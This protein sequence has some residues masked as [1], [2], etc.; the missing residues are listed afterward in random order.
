[1]LTR[2]T[3]EGEIGK[4][5]GISDWVKIDQARISAFADATEDWQAIHLDADAGREAGFDGAVAHGYLTLSMLSHL[6]Y[7]ALPEIEG[8]RASV[9]YGFDR[10]R[11]V[12]PVLAGAR[13]RAHFKLTGVQPRGDGLQLRLEVT[14]DIEGKQRPAL[15]AEWL[16]L[17]LF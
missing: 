9:N 13:I 6:A 8:T 12:A 3:L 16:V 7:D 10:I 5:L 1:M 17:Y 2:D 15:L 14:V 11:F 4:T